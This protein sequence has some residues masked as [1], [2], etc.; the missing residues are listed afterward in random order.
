[1]QKKTTKNK[2]TKTKQKQSKNQKTKQTKPNNIDKPVNIAFIR[3]ILTAKKS[4]Y[5]V[6]TAK[7]V[8]LHSSKRLIFNS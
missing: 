8:I 3:L 6:L 4:A 1:M 7:T 2:Q 5:R